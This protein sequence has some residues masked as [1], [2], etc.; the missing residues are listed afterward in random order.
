MIPTQDAG[1]LEGAGI[2]IPAFK[3]PP[4]RIERPHMAP[5]ATALSTELRGRVLIIKK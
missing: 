3:L 1:G 2:G 5:E 4:R